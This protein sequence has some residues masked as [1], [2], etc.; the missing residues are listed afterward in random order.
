MTSFAILTFI[1]VYF[2]GQ[3]SPRQTMIV[4]TIVLAVVLLSPFIR[5]LQ[6]LNIVEC[7]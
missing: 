6:N 3:V 1:A 4:V 5:E 7:R 2:G